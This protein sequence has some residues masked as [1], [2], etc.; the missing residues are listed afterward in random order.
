MADP[1]S[2]VVLAADAADEQSN[3]LSRIT[4]ALTKGLGSAAVS[5]THSIYNTVSDY[6]DGEHVDTE[7]Q[8]RNY[9]TQWG[10]YYNDNKSTIDFT[11]FVLGSIVPGTLAVKGLK[12]AQA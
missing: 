9:D 1:F 2:P 3:T 8:L 7:E 10:D 11:G 4:D 12:L 6:F 5:G